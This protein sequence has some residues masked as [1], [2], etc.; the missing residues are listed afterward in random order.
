[1]MKLEEKIKQIKS[2]ADS[3]IYAMKDHKLV[4]DKNN[5]SFDDAIYKMH[6]A[7]N[8][9]E[10]AKAYTDYIQLAICNHYNDACIIAGIMQNAELNK[11]YGVDID[12]VIGSLITNFRNVKPVDIGATA[13]V[14]TIDT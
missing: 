7:A 12:K 6:N 11:N 3:A 8:K 2:E 1:M 13:V 10:L 5:T 14:T 9:D 4:E